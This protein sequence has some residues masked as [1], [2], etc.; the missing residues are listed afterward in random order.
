MGYHEQMLESI[1]LTFDKEKVRII[2]ERILATGFTYE[3]K[4]KRF[5]DITICRTSDGAEY[6]FYNNSTPNGFFLVGFSV[7]IGGKFDS[8]TESASIKLQV[9]ETYP[10][11]L[12]IE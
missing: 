12:D 1:T 3:E 7:Q 11:Y 8:E 9:L 10:K 4:K 2:K 6:W 5:P